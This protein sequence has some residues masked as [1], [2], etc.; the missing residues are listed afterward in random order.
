MKIR[1]YGAARTVTGSQHLI[2]V[3]GKTILLECGV[4]QGK[5]KLFYERNCCFAFDPKDVD[6]VI[7]SH[8]HID[9]SGNLPNL[10]KQGYQK[11]IFAT[12]PT[13]DLAGIM[14]RDSAKTTVQY[15]P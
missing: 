15:Q 10:V 13:A 8:A 9:H 11:P 4:Y 7:L 6:A 3:N 5:R 14:L 1:F 12:A 2:E